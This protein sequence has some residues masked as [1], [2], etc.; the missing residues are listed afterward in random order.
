MFDET[1]LNERHG[2]S[3]LKGD[4]AFVRAEQKVAELLRQ[5]DEMICPRAGLALLNLGEKC[6]RLARRMLRE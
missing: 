4:A 1:T 2:K 3:R 6:G 5:G